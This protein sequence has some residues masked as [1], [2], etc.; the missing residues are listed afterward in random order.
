MRLNVANLKVTHAFGNAARTAPFGLYGP[1]N[2][3]IDISLRRSFAIPHF[4]RSHHLLEGD[5]YNVTN[6]TQ[7]G[8]IGTTFGGP[9]S[10]F[11]QVSSQANLSRDAQL[12]A[13]F[14]F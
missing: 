11:G 5:L 12:A 14:E 1:G 9:T 3:D 6:H 4:E 7:F 10:N 2:Y 13:R 8:G